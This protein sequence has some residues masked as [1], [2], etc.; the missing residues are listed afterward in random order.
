MTDSTAA[1]SAARQ[2]LADAGMDKGTIEKCM[3]L[4]DNNDITAANKLISEY[5]RQLLDTVHSCNRQIDCLDYFTYTL[6]KNGG[7]QK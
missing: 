4:I 3:T 1:L 2:N 6:D 7:I 5:R